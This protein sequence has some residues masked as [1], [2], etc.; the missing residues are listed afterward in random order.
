M[1]AFFGTF[2]LRR[3]RAVRFGNDDPLFLRFQCV[4]VI[5]AVVCA[6]AF[7]SEQSC[8]QNCRRCPQLGGEAEGRGDIRC[9]GRGGITLHFL[10]CIRAEANRP[11]QPLLAACDHVILCHHTAETAAYA[12][13]IGDAVRAQEDRIGVAQ[14]AANIVEVIGEAGE[15]RARDGVEGLDAELLVGGHGVLR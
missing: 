7:P 4:G 6:P 8:C 11:R 10:Q 15:P 2:V 5:R 3:N 12:V 1:R 13:C 9:S 14:G